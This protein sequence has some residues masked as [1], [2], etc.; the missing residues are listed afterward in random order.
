MKRTRR[1][2]IPLL[3][4]LV[5]ED[6]YHIGQEQNQH[7]TEDE[8]WVIASVVGSQRSQTRDRRVVEARLIRDLECDRVDG[9]QQQQ[10]G[11]GYDKE[12]QIRKSPFHGLT[13]ARL[14]CRN[15]RSLREGEAVT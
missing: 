15:L 2:Q 14:S 10:N 11:T 6:L 12:A 13:V 3:V 9:Q 5:E 8:H 4:L 7:P 1:S